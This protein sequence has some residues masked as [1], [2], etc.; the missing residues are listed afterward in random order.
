MAG[1]FGVE[2]CGSPYVMLVCRGV[3]DKGGLLVRQISDSNLA[4]ELNALFHAT[5]ASPVADIP[6][7][8]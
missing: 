7:S 2:V 5:V 6:H 8:R 4:E 3:K 1:A